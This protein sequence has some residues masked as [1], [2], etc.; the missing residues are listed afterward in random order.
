MRLRALIVGVFVSSAAHAMG[1]GELLKADKQFAEGYIFGA[2]EYQIAVTCNDDVS[3]RRQEI[4]K[5][6]VGGKFMSEQ[7]YSTVTTY[8]RSH[9]NQ[10]NAIGAI[11]YAIDE[12]CPQAGK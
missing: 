8:I 7:L 1:A 10:S 6:L 2:I 3:A 12:V 5:C 9:P 4:R 11:I